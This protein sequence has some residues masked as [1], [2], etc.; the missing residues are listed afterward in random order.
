MLH[1][2]AGFGVGVTHRLAEPAMLETPAGGVGQFFQGRDVALAAFGYDACFLS[3][4]LGSG[5]AHACLVA[6][7]AL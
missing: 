2:C 1:G 4:V 3:G 5:G 6:L 7:S